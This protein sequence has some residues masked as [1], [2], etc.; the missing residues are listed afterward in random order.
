MQEWN[1]VQQRKKVHDALSEGSFLL[2][3]LL[4][5]LP[6]DILYR[7]MSPLMSG[8]DL[9]PRAVPL[10]DSLCNTLICTAQHYTFHTLNPVPLLRMCRTDYTVH[11]CFI[12]STDLRWR[13]LSSRRP[14]RIAKA[15]DQLTDFSGCGCGPASYNMFLTRASLKSLCENLES[16][17]SRRMWLFRITR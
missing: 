8:Y 2:K 14:I 3:K 13:L 6:V 16:Q 5:T 12:Y 15:D 10:C 1:L 7:Q 11:P 17:D 4:Y 9:P